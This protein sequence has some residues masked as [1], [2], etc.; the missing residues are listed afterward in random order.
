VLH[1]QLDKN[2]VI[3][4]AGAGS[5]KTTLLSHLAEDCPMPIAWLRLESADRQL[6]RYI[7]LLISAIRR[8]YPTIDSD[9]LYRMGDLD[10]EF[11]QRLD[12]LV[13]GVVN[14][15]VDSVTGN[16]LIALDD[17][18]TVDS[19]PQINAFMD[20]LINHIPANVHLLIASRSAPPLNLARLR[21][22]HVLAE[23]DGSTLSFT[24]EEI[25][26]LYDRWNMPLGSDDASLLSA[27]T[28]GWAAGLV[29]FYQLTQQSP[30]AVSHLIK[31]L[32]GATDYF[33]DYLASEV[34]EQQPPE[35]RSFLLSTCLLSEM[36]PAFCDV[37]LER[38]DAEQILNMLEVRHLFTTSEEV[39]S[40]AELGVGLTAK[41]RRIYHYH[42]LFAEFLRAKLTEV[43]GTEAVRKWHLRIGQCFEK[44]DIIPMP[45]GDAFL[46]NEALR[47]YFSGKWVDAAVELLEHTGQVLEQYNLQWNLGY[48][49]TQLPLEQAQGSLRLQLCYATE[50]RSQGQIDKA[51]NIYEQ[52]EPLLREQRDISGVCWVLYGIAQCCWRRFEFRKTIELARE[53]ID[54]QEKYNLDEWMSQAQMMLTYAY[55]YYNLA[56]L[57][58]LAV[59]KQQFNEA[60]VF[61]E[62]AMR[63]RGSLAQEGDIHL[64]ELGMSVLSL[65]R[66][67]FNE[68]QEYAEKSLSLARTCGNPVVIAESLRQLG[69]VHHANNRFDDAENCYL[70]ALEVFKR[71][72]MNYVS[73][74]LHSQLVR[75]NRMQKDTTLMS[76]CGLLKRA[77]TNF[78]SP[79]IAPMRCR[80]CVGWRTNSAT[81]MRKCNLTH[82]VNHC[83][84]DCSVDFQWNAVE[85]QSLSQIGSGEKSRHCSNF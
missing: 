84:F 81:L 20:V 68:A 23:L 3:L 42:P 40:S 73:P 5:G 65:Q 62:R 71:N 78:S 29:L 9:F 4:T 6:T 37:L 31:Q 34:F 16:L 49:V 52:A 82:C 14:A 24:P 44:W 26:Q 57:G 27:K 28:E 54:L 58:R 63:I 12:A 17:Y 30:N 46:V 36:T 1:A 22:N 25:S 41:N 76:V 79:N 85:C 56:T 83:K 53:M 15:L 48:W 74:I 33:Y 77:A 47:H 35:I 18:H 64:P 60:Q 80:C 21:A 55:L 39:K 72:S 61:Y 10:D 66:G 70:K 8:V 19:N 38:C 51:M 13:A 59:A 75:R 32:H 45:W 67:N 43:E 7:S 50:L 11:H 69:H 2:L